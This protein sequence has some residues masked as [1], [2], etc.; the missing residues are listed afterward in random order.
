MNQHNST[1]RFTRDPVLK[2]TKTNNKSV[3]SFT[4]AVKRDYKDKDGKYPV[5]WID[6]VAWGPT[7]ELIEKYCKKGTLVRVTGPVEVNSYEKDGKNINRVEIRVEEIEFLDQPNNNG[8]PNEINDFSTV[9][10]DEGTL[11]FSTEDLNLLGIY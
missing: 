2:K 1:G 8:Q 7:A 3:V 9:S 6:Y 4:L 10:S 11:P 5:D